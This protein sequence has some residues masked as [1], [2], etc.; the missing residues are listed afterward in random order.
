MSAR[1]QRG[2]WEAR[3]VIAPYVWLLVFFLAPFAI[4]LKISFADPLIAS[5][6]FSELIERTA[7]GALRLRATLDN[8]RY[9][10]EDQLYLLTYLSSLKLAFVS[11]VLCLLVGYPMAYAIAR[12]RPP[13][14]TLLLLLVI[15]PFWISFLLRV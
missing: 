11:T 5:P 6:P 15:L 9:L 8:Y 7:H 3:V 12:A 4:I 14:R 10:F 1:P 2:R 13:R